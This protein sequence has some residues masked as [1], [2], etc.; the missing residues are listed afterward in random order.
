VEKERE[1]KEREKEREEEDEYI[2]D[3][4]GEE[5]EKGCLFFHSSRGGSLMGVGRVVD[6]PWRVLMRQ[7]CL[8]DLGQ[9]REY[10]ENSV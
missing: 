7:T 10:E 5:G 6:G 8:W 2:I 4:E 1:G 9:T 3:G